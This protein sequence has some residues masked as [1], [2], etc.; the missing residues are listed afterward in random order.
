MVISNDGFNPHSLRSYQDFPLVPVTTYL[1]DDDALIRDKE[2]LAQLLHV[3]HRHLSITDKL[4][5]TPSSINVEERI[6]PAL[7]IAPDIT[8]RQA[9][10]NNLHSW[11][12]GLVGSVNSS[13]LTMS[14]VPVSMERQ[15]SKYDNAQTSSG[16][17]A[18]GRKNLSDRWSLSIGMGYN[19]YKNQS[20]VVNTLYYDKNNEIITSGGEY[21]Y[22]ADL[23]MANPLGD[24]RSITKIILGQ[25]M[26]QNDL[27]TENL[28]IR[29]AFAVATF[30]LGLD[31]RLVN[32]KKFGL[33]TGAGIAYNVNIAL[34]NEFD[35][36]LSAD[37]FNHHYQEAVNTLAGFRNTFAS[38]YVKLAGDYQLHDRCSLFLETKFGQSIGSL[39]DSWPA[40]GPKT[41]LNELNISIGAAYHF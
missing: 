21:I 22:N 34:K 9:E 41:Y 38:A 25:I 28:F 17:K 24:H 18:F 7:N 14:H 36:T 33:Y 32:H 3:Q 8:N 10:N 15:L 27:I 29:Q 20:E 26:N 12:V 39:R 31:Y 35:V 19:K 23:E 40:S 11:S 1:Q 37:G 4:P 30:D 13:W 5:A 2:T 16:F 6:I